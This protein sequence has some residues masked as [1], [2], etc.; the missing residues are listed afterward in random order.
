MPT[1]A[2]ALAACLTVG[3]VVGWAIRPLTQRYADSS[4]VVTWIQV[5]ALF[6]VAAML[7]A[8]AWATHRTIARRQF[9]EPHRAVNRLVLA[10]ACALVGALAAGGYAGYAV[11]WLGLPA[12]LAD[13]RSLRS[14]IA[15]VGGG[16]MCGA[17]L[18]LERACRVRDGGDGA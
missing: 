2:G 17:A 10:K 5:L 14:G 8:T 4:P 12:E 11:A 6:L 16:L 3:L 9:L 7:G 1:A 18:L 15:A 13:Q